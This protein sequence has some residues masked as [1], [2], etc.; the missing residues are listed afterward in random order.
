MNL[1]SIALAALAEDAAVNPVGAAPS[2][3]KNPEFEEKH[4]RGQ[5]A[6]KGQ[7]R[8]S[9]KTLV[10]LDDAD[11]AISVPDYGDSSPSSVASEIAAVRARYTNPDGS[12]KPSFGRAPNGEKSNLNEYQ[13]LLVRTPT[14]K[15]WFGDWEAYAEEQ[16]IRERLDEWVSDSEELEWAKGKTLTECEAKFGDEL[17]PIAFLP[18]CFLSGFSGQAIDNRIYSSKGY[19]LDHMAN[20]GH[21]DIGAA[22]YRLLQEMFDSPDEVIKDNRQKPNGESRDSLLF[23]KRIAKNRLAAVELSEEDGH[24]VLHKSL[25]NT[26]DRVYPNLPRVYLSGGGRSPISH[27]APFGVAPGGSLSARDANNVSN[28]LLPVNPA[29]VS[30]IVDSNGEP[31]VVYHGSAKDFDDFTLDV[32]GRANE[33]E[34]KLGIWFFE[35]RDYAEAF[36]RQTTDSPKIYESFLNIRNPKVYGTT[37]PDKKAEREIEDKIKSLRRR[38]DDLK[39]DYDNPYDN[40]RQSLFQA[41]KGDFF[42]KESLMQMYAGHVA[43]AAEVIDAA[44]R[45]TATEK[46]IDA[47]TKKRRDMGYTDSYEKMRTDMA[48][49][50]GASAYNANYMGLGYAYDDKGKAPELFRKKLESEGYDGVVMN[51]TRFDREVVGGRN[52]QIVALSPDELFPATKDGFREGATFPKRLTPA[53][54]SRGGEPPRSP[55]PPFDLQKFVDYLSG[56]E[57]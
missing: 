13:W 41:A 38:L 18:T 36:A 31:R 4:K 54:D 32:A 7:F 50:V 21:A 37:E 6:N 49:T 22:E 12:P 40:L 14:F 43:D 52:T 28:F 33:T 23:V 19:L 27:A 56:K 2:A 20:H 39:S 24:I 26:R 29:S 48:A 3:P 42:P 35:R 1:R 47:L 11:A 8:K 53:T 57:D 51:D 10:R 46:D 5:P 17:Q 44:K 55:T 30:K 45:Y 34:S 16:S 15:K 9:E 25:Y